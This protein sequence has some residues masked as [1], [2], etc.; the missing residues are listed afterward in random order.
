DEVPAREAGPG[1]LS[2][3]LLTAERIVGPGTRRMTPRGLAPPQYAEFAEY[4]LPRPG[5]RNPVGFEVV[6]LALRL[7]G[8]RQPTWN[9]NGTHWRSAGLILPW[10]T[11]ARAQTVFSLAPLA[12]AAWAQ[13]G[14]CKPIS[15][16]CLPVGALPISWPSI[17]G[18]LEF[19]AAA[20]G[21]APAAISAV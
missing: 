16:H 14:F 17:E 18:K 2:H 9:C 13:S 6:G 5:L 11:G 21:F 10:S 3:D 1:F 19:P 15:A 4:V 7:P 8:K 12:A 20:M